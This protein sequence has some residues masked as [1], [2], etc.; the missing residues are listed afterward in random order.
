MFNY[1]AR[2]G[3]STIIKLIKGICHIYMSFQEPILAYIAASSLPSEDKATI[4]SWLNLATS[5]CSIL[6]QIRVSY[7]R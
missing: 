4:T 6:T 7:E 3:V 2:N 5:A 1:G